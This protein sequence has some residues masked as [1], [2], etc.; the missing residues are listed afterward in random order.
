VTRGGVGGDGASMGRLPPQVRVPPPSLPSDV[1][2]CGM[3]VLRAG[4]IVGRAGRAPRVLLVGL[5]VVG[6][7]LLAAL[8][9]SRDVA[10]AETTA[11][12]QM[13]A[14]PTGKPP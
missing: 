5:V 6:Y 1:S 7:G 3:T 12:P 2:L 11:Q 14:P 10:Q 8:Y 4:V 13:G 9:A